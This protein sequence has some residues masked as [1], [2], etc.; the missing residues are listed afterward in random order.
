MPRVDTRR[1]LLVL[2]AR[3]TMF[4]HITAQQTLSAGDKG[5]DERNGAYETV[6][7]L[8]EAGA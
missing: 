2:L 8:V 6:A 5:G 3:V 4:A 7:N 1:T